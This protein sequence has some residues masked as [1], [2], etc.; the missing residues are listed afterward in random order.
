LIVHSSVGFVQVSTRLLVSL[1]DSSIQG[2]YTGGD[3]L[4]K[5]FR[6]FRFD[7]ELYARFKELVAGSGLTVTE[8][9][10]RFMEACVSA[11]AVTFPTGSRQGVEAEARVLL[12][13]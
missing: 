1:Y 10:E 5:A 3:F 7:P 13:W 4:A 11:R 6:A 9:F 12:A 2:A 8:A